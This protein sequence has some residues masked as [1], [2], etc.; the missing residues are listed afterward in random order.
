MNYLF[1]GGGIALYFKINVILGLCELFVLQRKDVPA[2]LTI[3][4]ST[5]KDVTSSMKM[6]L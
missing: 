6:K 2:I 4:S 1:S 5:T 3:T